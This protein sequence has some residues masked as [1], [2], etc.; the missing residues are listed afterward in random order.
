MEEIK[1]VIA[2]IEG[3]VSNLK[4]H[5]TSTRSENTELKEKVSVLTA[6]LEEREQEVK[7]FQHKIDELMQQSSNQIS[8]D[9]EMNRLELRE[10]ID[11][12]VKEID[13]CISR[14][15]VEK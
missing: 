8:S 15:K 2:E 3:K 10:E 5:L 1:T 12:L 14:L 4:L 9:S 11:A 7:D 6:R 13:D